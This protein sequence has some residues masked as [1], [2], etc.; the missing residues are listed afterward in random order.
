MKDPL[1]VPADARPVHHPAWDNRIR[2]VADLATRQCRQKDAIH[3]AACSISGS[4]GELI[5]NLA[6]TATAE[7]QVPMMMLYVNDTL[8]P[9][10]EKSLGVQF[11]TR[12]LQ[13][14]VAGKETPAALPGQP[15]GSPGAMNWLKQPSAD[16]AAAA[17]AGPQGAGTDLA[18]I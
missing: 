5:V 15:D 2:Q 1:A 9:Q 16:P 8:L 11:E 14:S 10:M 3:S 17:D 7:A 6:C 18:L 13:F 12:N 4:P